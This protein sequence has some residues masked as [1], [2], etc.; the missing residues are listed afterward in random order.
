M[1]GRPLPDEA[2]RRFRVDASNNHLTVQ[3]KLGMLSLVLRM[4]VGG[5]MLPVKHADDDTEEH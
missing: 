3:I 1:Q 5:L 4:E 2:E